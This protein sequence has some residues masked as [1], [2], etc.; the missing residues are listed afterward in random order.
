MTFTIAAPG[1]TPSDLTAEQVKAYKQY[2]YYTYLIGKLAV[3]REEWSEEE[4]EAYSELTNA[5]Y[6]LRH[7]ELKG[8]I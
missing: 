1:F 4:S 7:G 6:T 2:K 8:I 5:V 3:R